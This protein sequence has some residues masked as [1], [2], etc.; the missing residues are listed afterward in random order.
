VITSSVIAA[1]EE[2]FPLEILEL[3]VCREKNEEFE[4][5]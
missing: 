2:M 4:V 5:P 3:Q 1:E